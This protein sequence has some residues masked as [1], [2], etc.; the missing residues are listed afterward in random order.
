MPLAGAA[1]VLGSLVAACGGPRTANLTVVL[2]DFAFTP[3]DVTVTAGQDVN[4]TLTNNGSVD[5]E[6]VLM[7]AGYQ[8]TVP[9]SDDD[10]PHVYWEAEAG[11]GETKSFTF[12]APSEPGDYQIVCGIPGHIEAGMVGTLTVTQ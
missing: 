7:E 4:L 11:A 2:T 1:L 8:V 6:W 12:T 3:A 10:E 9:F 5:H